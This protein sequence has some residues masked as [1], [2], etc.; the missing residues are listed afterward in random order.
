MVND[1]T[2]YQFSEQQFTYTLYFTDNVIKPWQACIQQ[3]GE[4]KAQQIRCKLMNKRS[5]VKANM[6]K[7]GVAN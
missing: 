1:E 2:A 6:K 5:Q 4:I 3:Y 7:V